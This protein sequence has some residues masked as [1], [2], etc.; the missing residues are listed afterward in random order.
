MLNHPKTKETSEYFDTNTEKRPTTMA[1]SN[2]QPTTLC[3]VQFEFTRIYFS[4]FLILWYSNF[5]KF[6]SFFALAYHLA[7]PRAAPSLVVCHFDCSNGR[8][9]DG[10]VRVAQEENLYQSGTTQDPLT[11]TLCAH[12]RGHFSMGMRVLLG[13]EPSKNISRQFIKD[14]YWPNHFN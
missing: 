1:I 9:G 5:E 8:D 10:E 13:T 11:F 3:R 14:F 6:T 7:A 12:Y 4:S 2:C